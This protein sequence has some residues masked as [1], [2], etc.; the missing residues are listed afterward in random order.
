MKDLNEVYKVTTE[1]LAL[2]QLYNNRNNLVTF[3][4]F[5]PRIRKIIYITNALEGF[6][7]Q[8]LKYTKA[9]TIFLI[10]ESL[11]KCVYIATMEIMEKWTQPIPNW[12][13][14]LAEITLFF[15]E[16]LSDELAQ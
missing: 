8:V 15:S 11:N 10:D 3:F 4:E 7:R 16:E 2:V 5:S 6:N 9:R 1:E 12:S 14:T 13:D